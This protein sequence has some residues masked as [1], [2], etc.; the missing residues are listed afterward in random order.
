M[1]HERD[2]AVGFGD[3]YLPLDGVVR[4][5][6]LDEKIVQ[7]AVSHAARKAGIRTS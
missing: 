6:H 2:L 5:H 4:R 7:R 1:L 3:V